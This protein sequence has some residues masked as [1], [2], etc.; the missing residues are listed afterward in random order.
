MVKSLFILLKSTKVKF[1]ARNAIEN[2]NSKIFF[3]DEKKS[4]SEI[5]QKKGDSPHLQKEVLRNN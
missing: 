4:G 3:Y 5:D 1:S 2:L